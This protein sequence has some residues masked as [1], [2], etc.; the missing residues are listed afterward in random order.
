MNA[1][2]LTGRASHVRYVTKKEVVSENMLEERLLHSV[3]TL[4]GGRSFYPL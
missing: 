1:N 3:K 2:Y 4:S